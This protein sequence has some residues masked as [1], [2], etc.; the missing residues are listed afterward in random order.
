ME[1]SEIPCSRLTP[2]TL[3]W[4]SFFTTRPSYLSYRSTNAHLTAN[5]SNRASQRCTKATCSEIGTISQSRKATTS[6]PSSR[7]AYIVKWYSETHTMLAR[8]QSHGQQRNI[9]E[10]HAY[11]HARYSLYLFLCS[12]GNE[13]DRPSD[14]LPARLT[15]RHSRGVFNFLMWRSRLRLYE[16]F[17]IQYLQ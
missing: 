13:P 12:V 14:V 6:C 16:R 4:H 10:K 17:W 1:F 11:S 5:C 3:I 7:T 8:V 2:S 9:T 15:Q